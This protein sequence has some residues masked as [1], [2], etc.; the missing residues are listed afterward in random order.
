MNGGHQAFHNAEL[1]VDHL[2]ERRQAVG[3]AGGVGHNLHILG[4]LVEV[5]AAHKGGS[6]LILRGSGDNDL[7]GAG[8]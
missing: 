8:R 2:S 3:G 5:D 4:V 1:V 6:I 7:L